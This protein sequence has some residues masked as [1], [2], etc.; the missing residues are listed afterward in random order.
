[1]PTLSYQTDSS[2]RKQIVK[3][4]ILTS[5]LVLGDLFLRGGVGLTP[6]TL[7]IK[8]AAAEVTRITGLFFLRGEGEGID[9]V[10]STADFLVF[11]NLPSTSSTEAN[12]AL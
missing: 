7:F 5:P 2:F 9:L 8:V 10:L 3:L 4:S 12:G 6:C 11:D 1:M